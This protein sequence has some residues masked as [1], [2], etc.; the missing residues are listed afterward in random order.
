MERFFAQRLFGPLRLDKLERQLRTS[1]R[2]RKR[3]G[4]LAATRL[5]QQVADTDRKLKI[6]IQALEDGIEPDLV[7]ARIAELRAE[8]DDYQAALDE[9]PAEDLDREEDDLAANLARIPDLTEQL[10]AAPREIKRQT[11][12]AFGLHIAFDKAQR[13]IEISA[14]ITEAVAQAFENT[15]ALQSEGFQV[16]V[17]DIA[18]AGFEP[19]TF[20]L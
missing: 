1:A 3:G 13:S 7:T 19:A 15:K 12:E 16:T 14:T 9:L 18:G 8:R 20:G 17:S 5:R 4:K 6:Q 2:E 10:R 11:F